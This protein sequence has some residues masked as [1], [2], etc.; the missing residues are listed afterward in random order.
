MALF[1][2]PRPP[3]APGP[4]GLPYDFW[5]KAPDVAIQGLYM[6]Y[7]HGMQERKIKMKDVDTIKRWT[8]GAI[9]RRRFK[10]MI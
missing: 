7:K 4:D 9:A 6:L 5:T 2:A 3:S 10:K 1:S 8:Q